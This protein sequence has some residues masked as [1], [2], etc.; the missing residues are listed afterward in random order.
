[1]LNNLRLLFRDF[2][3]FFT[4]DFNA[5]AY[6][7]AVL[8]IACSVLLVYGLGLNISVDRGAVPT[9][10]RLLNLLLCYGS[11][12]YMVS[13]P[14]LVIKREY[15]TLSNPWFYIKSFVFIFLLSFSSHISW[16]ELVDLSDCRIW[17]DTY[18]YKLLAYT[19][20]TTFI[21]LPLIF[22]RGFFDRKIKSLYG[23]CKGTHHIRAYLSLYI[24]V[25]PL[26]IFASFTSD[27]LSYYPVYKP[28]L[29][30]NVFDRPA[31]L[32]TFLFEL[33]YT[34]NFIAVEVFFRGA[35]VIGMAKLLGRNAV[36][37][38]VAVYVAIHFG[39]PALEAISALFGGY[40]LGALAF[41]TRHIWGGVIIHMGIALV[42]EL[43]RFFE[44]YILGVG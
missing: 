1:M 34:F 35:L 6:A 43:L 2:G 39:K 15:A 23:L 38:M 25:F 17:E 16:R 32:N 5:K 31:W 11:I 14:I 13:I 24:V 27:F 41:Q 4:Q 37:P 18:I 3:N 28:W 26:L 10:S 36:L 20:H 21:V 40:F 8:F 29:F 22:I 42:I 33:V 7:Y 19:R 44:H 9:G 12:Y 30:Q